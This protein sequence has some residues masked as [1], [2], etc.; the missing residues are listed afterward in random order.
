MGNNEHFVEITTEKTGG[1]WNDVAA[2][3]QSQCYVCEFDSADKGRPDA[4]QACLNDCSLHGSCNALKGECSC[5]DGWSG[6]DCATEKKASSN[7]KRVYTIVD[8]LVKKV[9]T[10]KKGQPQNTMPVREAMG[11]CASAG[12]F[13][14]TISNAQDDVDLRALLKNGCSNNNPNMPKTEPA[15]IPI[16]L[17]DFAQRS[18][19]N[20]IRFQWQD[21]A[22]SAERPFNRWARGEP[23]NVQNNEHCVVISSGGW[24]DVQ[25]TSLV[26][27]FACEF[28]ETKLSTRGSIVDTP[29]PEP[30]FFCNFHRLLNDAVLHFQEQVTFEYPSVEPL[31]AADN[32]IDAYPG[33]AG[34]AAGMQTM[35]LGS[36]FGSVDGGTGH[37]MTSILRQTCDRSKMLWQNR[38]LPSAAIENHVKTLARIAENSPDTHNAT[39]VLWHQLGGMLAHQGRSVEAML[40]YRACTTGPMSPLWARCKHALA[41]LRLKQG[42]YEHGYDELRQL[43]IGGGHSDEPAWLET[44]GVL[45]LQLGDIQGAVEALEQ[46]LHS[47]VGASPSAACGL[48]AA[49]YASGQMNEA[50]AMISACRRTLGSSSSNTA[51]CAASIGGASDHAVDQAAARTL[52][53]EARTKH[54]Y[55][56]L[57]AAT[58]MGLL[59]EVNLH[60]EAINTGSVFLQT[61]ASRRMRRPMV[62]V[63]MLAICHF[64]RNQ[65][66]LAVPLFKELYRAPPTAHGDELDALPDPLASIDVRY[67]FAKSVHLNSKQK[68]A[69]QKQWVLVMDELHRVTNLLSGY[70]LDFA[71]DVLLDQCHAAHQARNVR[72]TMR[73][74]EKATKKVPHNQAAKQGFQWAKNMDANTKSNQRKHQQQQQRQRQQQQQQQHQRQQQQRNRNHWNNNRRQQA[75]QK[76]YHRAL[77]VPRNS[78]AKQIKAA[79]HKLAMKWHPDKHTGEKEKE[80]AHKKFTDIA[81]AYEA[82]TAKP[83]GGQRGRRGQR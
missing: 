81:E 78:N 63:G 55:D 59:I 44:K 21:G 7:R 43:P 11:H 19:S 51:I 12:G 61:A 15:M 62:L 41:L 65:P 76:D 48:A 50:A 9:N 71:R 25:C 67:A 28:F 82:L 8:L 79:Y 31:S 45:L 64:K 39:A 42:W 68:L 77:G 10:K 22:M 57:V 23:N 18:G 3:Y 83:Q 26:S 40:A 30:N 66:N 60:V 24:N 58:Q 52:I 2:T 72:Q 1:G 46:A 33:G 20:K 5:Y 4:H 70:T 6:V 47:E 73:H 80:R 74:C 54:P 69:P 38:S 27:C 36:T 49:R 32:P 13:L 34:G 56:A 75:P 17:S 29:M 35:G 37:S 14:P 16:G 53:A